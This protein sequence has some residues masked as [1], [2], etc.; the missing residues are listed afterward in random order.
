MT[1]I[2]RRVLINP[3]V[4]QVAR[5]TTWPL[6]ALLVLLIGTSWVS[7]IHVIKVAAWIVTAL[8]IVSLVCEG[9][10]S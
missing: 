3:R 8:T 10:G 4:N 5:K 7:H 1:T 6:L 9:N 2:V